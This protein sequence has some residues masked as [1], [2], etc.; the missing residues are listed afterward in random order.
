MAFLQTTPEW[1]NNYQPLIPLPTHVCLCIDMQAH[2]QVVTFPSF[3]TSG[4]AEERGLIS[5]DPSVMQTLT[6]VLRKCTNAHML[7]FI[8]LEIFA[9]TRRRPRLFTD[10]KVSAYVVIVIT[11]CSWMM[12]LSFFLSYSSSSARLSLLCVSRCLFVK[13]FL[14]A[15]SLEMCRDLMNP[16]QLN[17]IQN[18][19]AR[20]TQP[21]DCTHALRY[22]QAYIPG[23]H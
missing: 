8:L 16:R 13:S 7:L 17:W 10:N 18:I 23:K 4:G 2:T 15:R 12:N 1:S 6:V 11:S 21:A 14:I 22:T 3:Y 5:L 20:F 19:Q 9:H